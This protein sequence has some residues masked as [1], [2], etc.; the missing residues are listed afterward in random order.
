MLGGTF[1]DWRDVGGFPSGSCDNAVVGYK[2]S[3]LLVNTSYTLSVRAYR[4]TGGVKEYSTASGTTAFTKG[5]NPP[6][7]SATPDLR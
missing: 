3:G 5:V 6:T 4:I 1:A 2:F 7:L